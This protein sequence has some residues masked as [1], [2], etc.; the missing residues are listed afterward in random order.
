MNTKTNHE[1][2][3]LA[4]REVIAESLAIEVEKVDPHISLMEELGVESLDFLD[5]VF[6]LE[7]LYDIQITRGELENAARGTMSEEEFAPNG[8]IS[9]LGLS[10]LRELMPE[11]A[12]RIKTGLRPV[13]ILTLFT[14]QTLVRLVENKLPQTR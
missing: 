14:V 1:A 6:K 10:R 5:I 3:E 11:V 4:V 13:Q 2:I 9:E 8:M 7:R 12:E